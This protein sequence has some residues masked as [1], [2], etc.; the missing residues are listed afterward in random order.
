MTTRVR[1]NDKRWAS[2]SHLSISPRAYGWRMLWV[3]LVR[4]TA[5]LGVNV[6]FKQIRHILLVDLQEG[7]FD[8]A[9]TLQIVPLGELVINLVKDTLNDTFIA[10]LDH[11]F[12]GHLVNRWLLWIKRSPVESINAIFLSRLTASS[13]ALAPSEGETAAFDALMVVALTRWVFYF[14]K[15]IGHHR[16]VNLRDVWLVWARIE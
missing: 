1:M 9:I 11:H 3:Y 7:Y 5:I 15:V 16:F 10:P 12:A 6:S 4:T 8:L 13:K 2:I 14:I